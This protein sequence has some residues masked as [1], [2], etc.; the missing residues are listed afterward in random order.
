M[1]PSQNHIADVVTK[2]EGGQRIKGFYKTSLPNKPLISIITVVYNG[3]KHLEETILS[4]LNQTYDNV[5]YLLIDGGSTDGTLDI[6]RKHE[7]KIDYWISEKD[8]GI[9]HA[10]NKGIDLANGEWMN[11]MNSGD[12]FFTENILEEVFFQ[13]YHNCDVIFGHHEVRYPNKTR[14]AL[15]GHP[16]LL[17]KGMQFSHQ[18]AFISTKRH[19]IYKYN[20]TNRIGADFE[21]FYKAYYKNYNFKFVDIIISSITSGGLSDIMRIES[22]V[23]AWNTVKKD[24]KINAY[25]IYIILIEILKEQTKLIFKKIHSKV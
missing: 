16:H 6:I 17:W 20:L 1:N 2:L 14:I 3:E 25:Y 22:I 24:S 19:K 13:K 21:F 12:I 18:S 15:A 11:F 8:S 4:V 10:M 23:G 9:Y 7:D 5:E